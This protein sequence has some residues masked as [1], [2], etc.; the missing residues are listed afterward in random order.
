MPKSSPKTRNSIPAICLRDVTVAYGDYV[1]IEDISFDVKKGQA[2][3]L[4]GPNGS[5][6]TTVLRAILGLLPVRA[7]KIRIDGKVG[8]VPQR[9]SFDPDFPLTVREFMHLNDGNTTAVKVLE[10]VKEVGLMPSILDARLGHL[11]GGQLQRILVAQAILHEPDLLILDEPASG[12]DV[13]G[14]ATFYD[15]IRHLKEEHDT[16]ILLVSHD[17][18]VVS[19]FVD[20]V[21]CVNRKLMCSGPPASALTEDVLNEVFGRHTSVYPH[22][23]HGKTSYGHHEHG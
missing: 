23:G 21:V 5:G 9:F 11:S 12:I 17:L 13:A 6:K 3:A 15:T 19:N 10:K 1:A 4:I 22:R 7:G 2:V 18:A 16:T 14:E 20:Q 8:Y